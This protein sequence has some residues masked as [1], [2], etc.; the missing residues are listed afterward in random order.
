M[1]PDMNVPPKILI[2]EDQYFVA[3]DCELHLRAAGMECAGLAT[4]AASALDLAE[5]QRPDLIIMDIRLASRADGVEAAIVIYERLGI[6]CIFTSAHADE[7][8]HREAAR[9]RPFAWVN[10]PYASEQL[11]TA[12]RDALEVLRCELPEGRVDSPV[13]SQAVH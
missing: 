12:V 9:A 11:I 5:R 6:R 13:T 2:V 3:V 1:R 8:T 7:S 10:K 4:T